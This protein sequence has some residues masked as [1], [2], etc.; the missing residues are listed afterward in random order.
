MTFMPMASDAEYG[1][2]IVVAVCWIQMAVVKRTSRNDDALL[3]IRIWFHIARFLGA[4][5]KIPGEFRV[6]ALMFKNILPAAVTGQDQ[7]LQTVVI[8]VDIFS[9]LARE[10]SSQ[11]VRSQKSLSTLSA[12][13]S[14]RHRKRRPSSRMPAELIQTEKV[15]RWQGL[16][17]TLV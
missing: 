1:L 9:L 14:K 17:T 15:E 5:I 12:P 16:A 4:I 13:T 3:R 7:S 11:L 8:F 2:A 10:A 6:R